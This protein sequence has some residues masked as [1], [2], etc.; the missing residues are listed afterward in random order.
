MNIDKL[1][2]SVEWGRHGEKWAC[3]YLFFPAPLLYYYVFCGGV[4]YRLKG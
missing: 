2:G 3:M 1:P 4:S